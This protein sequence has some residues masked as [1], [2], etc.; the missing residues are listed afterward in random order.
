MSS[1]HQECYIRNIPNPLLSWHIYISVVCQIVCIF[2]DKSNGDDDNDVND[3]EK[4]DDAYD[5]DEK[6]KNCLSFSKN[7]IK[8]WAGKKK[9]NWKIPTFPPE[10][11]K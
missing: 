8:I 7:L 4:N 11:P 1:M 9:W 3:D 10:K 5:D 2:Q 6:K